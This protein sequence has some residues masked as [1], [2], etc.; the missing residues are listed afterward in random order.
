MTKVYLMTREHKYWKQTIYFVENCSWKAG[1]FLAKKMTENEFQECERVCVICV[2]GKV[3]GFSTFTERDELSEQYDFTPFIRFVFVDEQYRGRRLSEKM[4][5]SIISYAK[6]IGY[7]KVYIMSGEIGLYE[8]YGFVKIGDYETIYGS[9]DQLFVQSIEEGNQDLELLNHL[10]RL[11][12]TEL[13]VVRIKRN[14]S[15]DT[16]NIVEWCK[17]KISSAHA[18]ISRKGKNWYANVDDIVITVNAHSYTI[19]TAHRGKR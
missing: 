6:E 9:I 12:T 10:D 13:G 3:A 5:Q 17:D 2:D 16:D 1:H 7:E 14:L 18:I 15:L 8:K 4:I 11:H 19:I